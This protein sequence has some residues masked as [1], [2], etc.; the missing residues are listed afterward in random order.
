MALAKRVRAKRDAE[1]AQ[2]AKERAEQ[3]RRQREALER[4]REQERQKEMERQRLSRKTGTAGA[5]TSTRIYYR[6]S[7][8]GK[9]CS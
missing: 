1:K 5:G 4:Q 6:P 8:N 9:R 7:P 2:E 3:I